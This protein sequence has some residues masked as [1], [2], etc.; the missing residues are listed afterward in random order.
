MEPGLR[1]EVGTGCHL[2]GLLFAVPL[3]HTQWSED[4]D[5]LDLSLKE[6]V[7]QWRDEHQAANKC[8]MVLKSKGNTILSECGAKIQSHP[9]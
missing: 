4:T 7:K 2:P 8:F 9:L 6:S 1:A 5:H 3:S